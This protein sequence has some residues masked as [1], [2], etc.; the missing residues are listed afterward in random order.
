MAK[1]LFGLVHTLLDDSGALEP[2]GTIEVYD[3][4]T[5]TQRTVYSDRG[6]TTT[7]GYQITADAAGRLPERWI[8]D[9]V[10]VKLVYKDS[11]GAT[12]ATRDYANDDVAGIET[13]VAQYFA[14]YALMTA[15][16]AAEGLVDNGLY[17]TYARTT[18]EDGGAGFWRYDAA[19]TSTANSGTILAIDGGGS[20]RFFRLV[21]TSKPVDARWFGFKVGGGNGDATANT[22]ALQAALN[23]FYWVG[24][25]A[26]TAYLNKITH[27]RTNRLSG[28][29]Q[30]ETILVRANSLNDNGIVASAKNDLIYEDFTIDGNRA[31]NTGDG[32]HNGIR[33]T[34]GCNRWQFHRV[35]A[36][37]W[38]GTFSGAAVGSGFA[39]VGGG[40]RGLL[41]HCWADDCYDGYVIDAHTDARD[42]GSRLTSCTRNGGLVSTASNRFEHH[43]VEANG[44]CTTHGGAGL[45]IIDSSDCKGYGGTFN[46]NTLGHG[47][48]HNGADRCEVHGGTFNSNGI[49]GLDFFDSIDG[50]V[51]GGY[52]AS[53]SI[54]GIEIDSASNGCLVVGFQGA[55]NTDV[56]I[57]V[58]RSADVQLIGCEG[59]VRAWDAAFI[60]SATVS[61]GGTG[62]TVGD[63]LTLSGG[64]RATAATFTVATLGGG[65]AVATVTVSNGGNY[66]TFPTEPASVTGGTGSGATFNFTATAEASSTNARLQITG[67][68]RSDTILLVTD[69]C[70][71]VRLSQVKAATVTD[72]SSEIVSATDC[73]NVPDKN[74]VRM[75]FKLIGANMNSTA[76]Q[77]FTKVGNFTSW[78]VAAGG[79]YRLV[80][81][82]VS[83]TTAAG[84]VYSAASKGGDQLVAN[85]QTYANASTVGTS[86]QQMT[87]SAL[88]GGVRTETPYLSLTTAQG[89]TATADLYIF[90]IAIS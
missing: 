40:S 20:G 90:G 38:R 25:P 57:S 22:T 21:D 83:L 31:N 36:T 68:H 45:Q 4:G 1:N 3:A 81:P 60:A 82:S 41:D 37:G 69:A 47:L 34:G 12:L 19:S 54:R 67:G 11:A 17:Y 51:Y 75:L 58:F 78:T 76:D 88:G 48:Q 59:N 30:T 29:G 49:S 63:V 71:D 65:G 16:T 56:D 50:K 80:N 61:A 26:G 73:A 14:T 42:Y 6:L 28:A 13:K 7:A 43:G 64:T 77:Q 79:T 32:S 46:S 39:S 62:Y 74:N 35:K 33:L 55:S 87:A 15:H 5:T 23:A 89:A 9:S 24:L 85:T 72:Q 44:N 27:T 8:A 2:G 53:N 86:S 10:V 70:T 52:A 66:W 84:G 18:E